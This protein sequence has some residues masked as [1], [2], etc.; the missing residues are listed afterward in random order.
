[1]TIKTLAE[2]MGMGIDERLAYLRGMTPEEKAA[3]AGPWKAE[4][5]ESMRTLK[6]MRRRPDFSRQER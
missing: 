2:V 3:A 6:S 4:W 5:A 1:M